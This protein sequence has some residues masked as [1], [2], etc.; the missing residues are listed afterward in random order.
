MPAQRTREM[1]YLL[2][3]FIFCIGGD[4][5][6]NTSRVHVSNFDKILAIL[7]HGI[8]CLAYSY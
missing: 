2:R 7:L 5:T 1:E 3:G 4:T 8:K 6:R